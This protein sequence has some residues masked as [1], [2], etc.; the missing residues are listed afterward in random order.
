MS[1]LIGKLLTPLISP[2]GLA[3]FLWLAGL[4]LSWWGRRGWGQGCRIAGCLLIALLGSPW[5]GERL[6]HSLES[7]YPL[8]PVAD[9]PTAEAIVVLGGFTEPPIPPRLDI[10]VDEGFDRLLHGLRLWR[11]GKAPLLVFSGGAIPSL[12]GS[13]MTEAASL[14][15][16]ALEYGVNREAMLLEEESRNTYENAVFTAQL[17]RQQGLNRVLLVTSASHMP[18]SV[19]AFRKQGLEIIP[20]PTDVQVVPRP[21]TLIQVLPGLRG[22]ECSNTALKEWFGRWTYWLRGWS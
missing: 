4:L 21:F 16:L 3:L 5:V 7:E 2:L 12:S 1:I 8:V 19:A 13:S 14:C 9:S 15:S 11:A 22:L 18:R 20:S 17:L 10:D 6:L